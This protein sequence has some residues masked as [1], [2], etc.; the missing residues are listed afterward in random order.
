[1]LV[2]YAIQFLAGM[3]LNLFVTIPGQHPGA[4]GA[5]YFTSSGRGLI[6]ALSGHGGFALATHAYIA[7]LLVTGSLSLFAISLRHK[8]RL[9]SWCGGIAAFFTVGAFFNG[10]SFIDYAHNFSSMIM[11]TCWLIA[12]GALIYGLIAAARRPGA[13]RP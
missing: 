5:E 13:A 12:V 7:L 1:M 11:A 4:N 10:L 6:W 3:S 8:D 2:G 9:W